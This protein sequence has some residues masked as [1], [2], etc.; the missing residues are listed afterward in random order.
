MACTATTAMVTSIPELLLRAMSEMLIV[1]HVS[2]AGGYHWNH[3]VLSQPY[4]SLILRWLALSPTGYCRRAGP[5]PQ[6][7]VVLHTRE[8]W[9]HSSPGQHHRIGAMVWDE[10]VSPLRGY[11]S[12]RVDPISV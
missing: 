6:G 9:S 10:K 1:A 12:R 2:M 3:V 8:R 11:K 7:R 5:D 4:Y